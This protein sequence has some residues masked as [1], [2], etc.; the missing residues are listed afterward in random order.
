VTVALDVPLARTGALAVSLAAATV[1]PQSA[2]LTLAIVAREPLSGADDLRLGVAFAD[3]RRCVARSMPLGAPPEPEG[4]AEREILLWTRDP[5]AGGGRVQRVSYLLWPLPPAG[6]LTLTF[7][8]PARGVGE[9][10]AEVDGGRLR[11]AAARVVE[12]WPDERPDPP[13]EPGE[14]WLRYAAS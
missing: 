12:L 7:V 13:A 11:E 9:V 6:P 14:G 5:G 10:T 3:G 1:G 4:D 2:A 8:W